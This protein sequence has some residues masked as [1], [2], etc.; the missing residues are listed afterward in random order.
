MTPPEE[1]VVL[2]VCKCGG[3][4]ES[5]HRVHRATAARC[6]GEPERV[7]FVRR[8]S[9]DQAEERVRELREA[10]RTHYL[11][12]IECDHN[13]KRDR[14]TCACSKVDLGWHPSVGAAVDA[15]HAHVLEVGA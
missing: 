13:R 14:P 6:T 7:E 2:Y 4:S 9:L 10:F 3:I 12:G 11:L 8:A 1:S 15:W 5:R